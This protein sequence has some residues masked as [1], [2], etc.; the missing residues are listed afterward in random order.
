MAAVTSG[1][2]AYRPSLAMKAFERLKEQF[3][4]NHGGL[5]NA[6]KPMIS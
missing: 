5:S 3:H 2:L 4:E 6:D 1:V